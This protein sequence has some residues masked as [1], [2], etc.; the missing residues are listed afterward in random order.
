[1]SSYTLTLKHKATGNTYT[2]DALDNYFGHHVYGYR[3]P[4]G[5]ILNAEELEGI[6][7]PSEEI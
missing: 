2:I 1:M 7:E 4:D 3:L 5:R 6:Y